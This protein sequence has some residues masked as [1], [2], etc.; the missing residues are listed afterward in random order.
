MRTRAALVAL[1]A[2][3][4]GLVVA[5]PARGAGKISIQLTQVMATDPG[6]G[7][8]SFDPSLD[9][10]KGQLEKYR[11]RTFKN[12]GADKKDCGEGEAATFSLSEAGYTVSVKPKGAGSMIPL[13]LSMKDAKGKEVMSTTIK[14]KDGGS[15]IVNKELDGKPACLFLV[16]TV[17]RN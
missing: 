15:T 11:Y 4:L 6:A 7:A 13:E 14:V 9:A 16:F 12:A 3:A 17:K 10:L 2:L 5:A 8:Q 1:V